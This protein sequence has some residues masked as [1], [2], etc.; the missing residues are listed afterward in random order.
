L[1]SSEQRH[2]PLSQQV[3]ARKLPKHELA[4]LRNMFEAL[5]AD[6]NGTISVDEL[7]VGLQK[8]GALL[9]REEVEQILDSVDINGDHRVDYGEFLAATVHLSKLNREDHLEQVPKL[10]WC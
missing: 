3:I 7:R 2:S 9:R 5:D 4:G 1:P 6:G 10:P 8:K